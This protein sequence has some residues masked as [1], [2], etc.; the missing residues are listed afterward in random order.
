MANKGI[1]IAQCPMHGEYYLDAP[2]SPCPS[3]EDSTIE[4]EDSG[5]LE[6]SLFSVG[7]ESAIT[8]AEILS[9]NEYSDD[10]RDALLTALHWGEF[11]GFNM[12]SIELVKSLP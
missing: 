6:R 10:V 4:N 2:D 5:S 9:I 8:G 7:G 3:C 1:G 12:E 11:K